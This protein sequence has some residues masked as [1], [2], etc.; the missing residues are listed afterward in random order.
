M[1]IVDK[2]K[3]YGKLI[4]AVVITIGFGGTM[5]VYGGGGSQPDTGEEQETNFTAPSQHYRLGSF[6]KS[7]TEQVV[8]SAR[9]DVVFVNA[10]Y[11]NES[12]KQQLEQLQPVTQN[13]GDRVYM[14]VIDT[15]T[16]IDVISRNGVNEFPAVVVQGGLMTQRGQAPQAQKVTNI[17]QLNVERAICNG[18]T[19]LGGQAA[20][21]QQVGAF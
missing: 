19:D 16:S 6:N 10:Y 17:T 11:E 8:I 14:Q 4:I 7:Y 18:L 21:C 20:K 15:S 5:F 3:Q 2:L 12:Q 13:F 9:D 1:G